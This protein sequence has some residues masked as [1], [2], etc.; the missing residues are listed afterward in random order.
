MGNKI[1]IQET[2]ENARR[3][4]ADEPNLSPA[5]KT[6]FELLIN[7]CLLLAGKWFPKNSKN[8]NIPPS[9][10]PNRGKISKSRGKRKP[11]GQP[12]HPGTTLK[13]V[14]NPDRIVP[15]TITRR[16]LPPG[17]W[18]AAGWEKR[19]VIEL[20]IQ[21]VVTEYRAEVLVNGQGERVTARFPE[22]LVQGVQYGESVKSHAVY[23]SVHQ[24]VPCERVSEHFENQI[25]IPLST[26]S[27]CNF[28]QEASNRLAW[29]EGWV[30]EKLQEEGVLNCDET[31]INTGGKRVWLHNVSGEGYT[32]YFPHEKRGKEGMDAMGTLGKAKGVLVHDYWKPYYGF[33]GNRHA[34]CNAHLIRELRLVTEEGQGWAQPVIDYLYEVN[35]EAEKAGG[36]LG[37][38]RQEEVR[39]EYR[40]LLRKGDKECPRGEAKPPG[41]R[42]RAAKPKSRNL[43]ERLAER[44][45]E[46][47][48]FITDQQVPFP[49]NQAERDV[50]MMKVHQK[51][52]GCFR[53]WE[54]AKI[55]CR[56]RSYI[57][58]C[59]KQGM[60]ASEAVKLVF[61]N[62]LPDFVTFSNIPAE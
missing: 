18:K 61:Q 31:G 14:D 1:N 5:L 8:S 57:S 62:K 11:G 49:N 52:S 25:N 7:L 48:R 43:L 27:L 59:L 56:I 55:Y 34:L 19:Q 2:I 51:I 30:A 60:T 33:T 39:Q 13:L 23:M 44:E 35:A 26:G 20:E 47:L 38:K 54:G 42:G 15:L 28:K 16:T 40:R 24:M 29:F 32:L 12:G 9:G 36:K 10:D 3:Q 45:D 58:T 37:K 4:I 17:E 41:K 53:S 6:T 46:V 50:R 21:R 22:G